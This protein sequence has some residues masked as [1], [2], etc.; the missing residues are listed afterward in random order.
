MTH[1]DPPRPGLGRPVRRPARPREDPTG[2]APA[3]RPRR[4]PATRSTGSRPGGA[5]GAAGPVRR[6]ARADAVEPA[7]AAGERPRA[8]RPVSPSRPA[9]PNRP[10]PP[11]PP[12]SPAR[13]AL[14]GPV[15]R[16]RSAGRAGPARP[17]NPGPGSP[18]SPAAGRTGSTSPVW[19]IAAGSSSTPTISTP[20]SAPA[21]R[22]LNRRRAL[23][24]LGTVVA[25]TAAALSPPGLHLVAQALRRAGP[26]RRQAGRA[27]ARHP[28]RRRLGPPGRPAAQQ[29]RAPTPTRTR[30][31]WAR[32]AGDHVR[33]NTPT[34]RHGG[35][36]R[37]GPGGGRRRRP[38]PVAVSALGTD[39]VRHLANRLTFGATPELIAEIN[40]IG[41]DQWL[42]QPARPGD[43]RR[44]QAGAKL[45][46]L[47]TLGQVRRPAAGRPRGQQRSRDRARPGDVEATIA[48]QIWSDRQLF[49]VMVDFWN[50]FLHVAAFFDGAEIQRP[51]FDTGRHPQVRAGQLP[52]HV[53]RGQPAPRP[54]STTWTRTS[55]PRTRSTRTWPGRTSSCTR[56][57]STAATPRST[58]GR[59][60]CCRPAAAS[61]TTSTSTARSSTSSARSRSWA[62]P[63]RTPPPDG[64]EAACRG[65]LPRT[66]PC[67]RRPPA[68][69]RRAW[70]PGWSPTPRRQTLV[71]R[72]ADDVPGEQGP[73]QADADH[74]ASARP[75]SGA[76][77]GRRCAARWSTWSPPTGRWACG[78]TPRPAFQDDNANAQPVP[79]GAAARS[80]HKMEELGQFPTGQPTPNGYP[81]VFVAWTSA[82][83]M[84]NG[85]NE[86]YDVLLGGRRKQFTYVAAGAA[87][88][89]RPP[90]TA[91]AYVD[92]LAK[93]LVHQTL[94]RPSRRPRC[95]ASP[96][97]TGDRPRSTPRFNGAIARGRPDHPRQPPAPPPVD[98][99]SSGED[100]VL[101]PCT[102]VPQTC[103]GW[104][105][106]RARRSCGPRPSWCDRGERRAA[107]TATTG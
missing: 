87:G 57:A 96:A 30:A 85:W 53:R 99:D 5:K 70:P 94:T 3:R 22:S 65:V 59:P 86:A 88:R 25:G 38:T 29:P 36:G 100:C 40:R 39:P 78:R 45:A 15:P 16:R 104:P 9:L 73:D 98:G 77:W 41:I 97:S 58:S 10:V 42:R 56:S 95:S 43:D 61:A 92:A 55:P 35:L 17:G 49:E 105:T 18:V 71:D 93:R 6:P 4:R 14:P 44:L 24:A 69:S 82:G 11:Q 32:P 91:G 75:S 76:R 54:C 84:V 62:S 19:T 33:K 7:A 64:G 13:P 46:E 51:S 37:P 27:V 101:G 107:A 89:R 34:H 81:D 106:T 68:T 52:G 28:A 8:N 26:R 80:R 2:A 72:V 1:W 74:A 102:R 79:A 90:A 47:T 60:R 31:T 20:T 67:T 63:T 21:T 48:R 83:T 103:G 66:W 12:V 23:L 50:D